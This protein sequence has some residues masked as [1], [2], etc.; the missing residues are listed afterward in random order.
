MPFR[1][2]S[3]SSQSRSAT[4]SNA[5]RLK[6]EREGYAQ[7]RRIAS[8]I[9]NVPWTRS[10]LNILWIGGPVTFLG[11]LGGFYLGYGHL[12]TVA[13]LVFF[14]FF[15][16]ITGASGILSTIVHNYR[17]QGRYRRREKRIAR[18]MSALP[19]LILATRNLWVETLEGDAR[20]REAA[21]LLLQKQDLSAAG[22]E[23]AASELLGD[24]ELARL[25]VSIDVYRRQGLYARIHDLNEAH[26]DALEQQLSALHEL[27]PEATNLLRE[28]LQGRVP[29]LRDGV[30]RSDNFIE[31]I[32]SAI[33]E[34]DE[35]LMTVQD[36]E[37]I[38]TLAFELLNGRRIPTL[39]FEYKGRWRLARTLDALEL[40]RSRY[41]IAQATGM[42]RLQALTAYLAEQSVTQVEDAAAGLRSEVLLERSRS[43]MDALAEQC[44]Q[45]ADAVEAG[46]TD[47]RT[48]LKAHAD[49]LSNAVRLFKHARDGYN[50]TARHHVQLMKLSQRWERLS[51]DVTRLQLRGLGSGLRIREDEI[52]LDD[53]AK[54]AFCKA[55]NRALDRYTHRVDDHSTQPLDISAAKRLAIDI[56]LALEPHIH[57]SHA[58]V[59]R[60]IYASHAADFSTLE[61]HLSG[62]TKAALGAAMVNEVVD[63]LSRSAESLA[64]ALV[65][66][67]RVEL[68]QDAISFLST[69][70]GA[71]ENTLNMVSKY[72]ERERRPVSYLSNRPPVMGEMS[73][74][75][76]RA[77]VRARQAMSVRA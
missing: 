34:D 28:R 2:L 72:D 32:L 36:V 49:T 40:A 48:A 55:L 73:R 42:S 67:Y 77:L 59:Q 68:E 60:A 12:P 14:F 4:S 18:V 31:R 63:D 19:E 24:D 21:T 71:R 38:L 27:A 8:A 65:R 57:L 47:K 52:G 23:L 37:E 76:Y 56:A 7:I 35:L 62:A 16:L 39:L 64:M 3:R 9:E 30:P 5:S 74:D 22:L 69:Q 33:E 53:R 1:W 54:G 26:R 51:S 15:T 66:H 10:L 50:Q 58:E 29:N 20:N 25:L 46:D 41:R 17:Q 61:R 44:M 43:A 45:L 13:N 70:Y 11:A 75:W 6:L